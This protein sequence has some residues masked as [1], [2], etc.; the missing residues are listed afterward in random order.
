MRTVTR[1]VPGL[2]HRHLGHH[3]IDPPRPGLQ[4]LGSPVSRPMSSTAIAPFVLF[5]RS[6]DSRAHAAAG[7]GQGPTDSGRHREQRVSRCHG[8]CGRQTM[9]RAHCTA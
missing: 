2:H 5:R 7:V 6:C 9:K 4:L 3:A 1:T 8:V